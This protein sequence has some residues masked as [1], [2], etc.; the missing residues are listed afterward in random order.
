[1]AREHAAAD[2]REPE[3][4]RLRELLEQLV[5]VVGRQ[6]GPLLVAILALMT[7]IGGDHRLVRGIRRALADDRHPPV[8]RALDC[9]EDRVAEAQTLD[10]FGS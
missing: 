2:R 3:L 5:D 6:R 9:G 1:L 4:A 7:A 8:L 10:R